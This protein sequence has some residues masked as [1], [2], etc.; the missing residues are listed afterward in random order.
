MAEPPA[1]APP[2]RQACSDTGIVSSILRRPSLSSRKTSDAVMSLVIEAG[3]NGSS[4]AFS[5]STVPLS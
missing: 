2:V 1:G 5:K 3:S 4:A